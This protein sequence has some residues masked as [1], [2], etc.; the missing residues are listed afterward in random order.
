MNVFTDRYKKMCPGFRL[1]KPDTK[2]IRVNTLKIDV[3]DLVLRLKKKG[4]K[5]DKIDFVDNGF[6]V[7][8]RFSLGSSAEYL[9][10]YLMMQEPASQAAIEVLSPEPG[11]LVLDMAAAP[12]AKTTHMSQLMK[13]QGS[14]VALDINPKRMASLVNNVQRMGCSNVLVYRKDA[15]Y[16]SDL[17]LKF[18][19]ILLDA[20]CSGNFCT[21]KDWFKKRSLGDFKT[22]AKKQKKLLEAGL[23]LLK[24]DGVLLY[25]TC[26]LEPEENELVV[27]SVLSDDIVLEKVDCIGDPGL[28]NVFGEKLDPSL[29]KC[30]RFWPHRTATQGFF[31]AKLRKK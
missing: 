8:S 19:K 22:M 31:I 16:A 9:L 28:V 7:K 29:K 26:S 6:H 13:N 30:V 25:S 4:V 1:E 18:D 11:D 20:P 12:G 5:L 21:E 14:I 24:K 2:S 27:D 3:Q 15:V 10:G 17:G 23:S